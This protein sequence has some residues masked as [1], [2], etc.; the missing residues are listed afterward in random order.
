[1]TVLG[2]GEDNVVTD[3]EETVYES[4][5]LILLALDKVQRGG[6]LL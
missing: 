5:D 6:G 1:V 2:I 4:V 3:V